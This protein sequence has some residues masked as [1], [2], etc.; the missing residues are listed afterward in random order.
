MAL[1]FVKNVLDSKLVGYESFRTVSECEL[2]EIRRRFGAH[3]KILVPCRP[4]RKDK[5]GNYAS[6]FTPGERVEARMSSKEA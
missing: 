5:M 4:I 6:I 3:D 1:N 2:R